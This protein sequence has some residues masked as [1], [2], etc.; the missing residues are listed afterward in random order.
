VGLCIGQVSVHDAVRGYTPDGLI[1]VILVVPLLIAAAMACTCPHWPCGGAAR[2]HGGARAAAAAAASR[3]A[4]AGPRRC[5][6]LLPLAGALALARAALPPLHQHQHC[7]FEVSEG[8]GVRAQGQ[9]RQP[10]ART[11]CGAG[12]HG[13]TQRTRVVARAP[14]PQ[15]AS[16][17]MAL[18]A[19]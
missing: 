18:L 8:L 2:P 17:G 14:A 3:L 9:R 15:L 4:A 5:L 12:W 11:V 7:C 6:L 1:L 10:V 16:C 19:A 13:A